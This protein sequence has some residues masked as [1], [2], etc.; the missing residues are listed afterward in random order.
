MEVA[1]PDYR[2][3]VRVIHDYIGRRTIFNSDRAVCDNAHGRR[4]LFDARASI[5]REPFLGFVCTKAQELLLIHIGDGKY[6]RRQDNE[7]NEHS[8]REA[9]KREIHECIYYNALT[10][11]EVASRAIRLSEVC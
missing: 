10:D 8:K 4:A 1:V 5:A 2:L 3:P 6:K 11:R 9:S 7:R